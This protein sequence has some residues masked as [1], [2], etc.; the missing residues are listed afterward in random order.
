MSIHWYNRLEAETGPCL[1]KSKL[2]SSKQLIVAQQYG[3]KNDFSYRYAA[4]ENY[5]DF[6]QYYLKQDEKNQTFNEVTLGNQNQKMRF[7]LDMKGVTDEKIGQQVVEKVMIAT[8]NFFEELDIK[9]KM[10]KNWIVFSSHGKNKLSYHL[11]V[12]KYHFVDCQ[13]V[14]YVYKQICKNLPQDIIDKYLDS[15]IYTKKHPLRIYGNFKV[16][17]ERIKQWNP[18]FMFKGEK[19]KTKLTIEKEN[20]DLFEDYAILQAGL[21]TETSNCKVIKLALPSEPRIETEVANETIEKAMKLLRSIDPDEILQL[22]EVKGNIICLRK[23][24][25]YYC[26]VCERNHDNE[27][28]F[29]LLI[30]DSI[31]FSCRR[32]EKKHLLGKGVELEAKI[33]KPEADEDEKTVKKEEASRILM[34]ERMFSLSGVKVIGQ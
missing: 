4:F 10:K 29:L 25:P 28:P 18:D 21:I 31:L 30:G 27:N 8:N 26:P 15:S 7:D 11:I 19:I 5:I 1:L 14:Q 16:E 3:K 13:T 17:D 2:I 33:K 34:R 9:L 22:A 20:D 24:K 23:T 6:W 12:D 32:N